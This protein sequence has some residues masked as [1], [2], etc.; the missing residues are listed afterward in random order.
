MAWGDRQSW[1]QW[2]DKNAKNPAGRRRQDKPEAK[3]EIGLPAYD[4][5]EG[6]NGGSGGSSASASSMPTQDAM[7]QALINIA[8]KDKSVAAAVEGLIPQETADDK[9]LKNQQQLLNK[10]RKCKQKISKREAAIA[11][12]NTMMEQF[13]EEMRKHIASEKQRHQGE[14]KELTQEVEELKEELVQLKKGEEKTPEPAI[15]LEEL[16]EEDDGMDNADLRQQ[17]LK[18]KQD[19]Q[20]A[21]SLAY[22]MKVQ[23]DTLIQYQQLAAGTCLP[24]GETTAIPEIFGVPTTP[25]RP[26]KPINNGALVK[27]AKA[28][29]GVMRTDPTGQRG[30]PYSKPNE[31]GKDG[32]LSKEDKKDGKGSEVDTHMRMDWRFFKIGQV[33]KWFCEDIMLLHQC[34]SWRSSMAAWPIL[35]QLDI[36]GRWFHTSLEISVVWQ[37][38]TTSWTWMRRWGILTLPGWH[39]TGWLGS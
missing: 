26:K 15:S 5:K 3:K 4:R 2:S 22:A 12:K 11:S 31:V 8:S 27:D 7:L 39:L 36:L 33:K 28:P 38:S 21:Q 37:R 25:Q 17:L 19:A 24:T 23:M 20:E 6:G 13:M 10:I 1:N 18:A 9:E 32:P 29:F 35:R 34:P 14:I 30:S 16:L